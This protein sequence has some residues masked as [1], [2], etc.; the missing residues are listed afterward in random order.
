MFLM[1]VLL[2]IRKGY[3]EKGSILL[4]IFVLISAYAIKIGVEYP[5][6]RFMKIESG[7]ESRSRYA[8]KTMDLFEDFKLAGAGVG[9]FRYAFP[10]Y[11]S[12]KDKKKFYMFAH[13]DWAQYLSEA[14]I[15]GLCLLLAGFGFYIF[16]TLRL[17]ARRK[18][19]YAVSLGVAPVVALTYIGLHS[20]G[21]FSLHTPAN[22]LILLAIMAIGYA[23]LHLERHSRR[24]RMDY[25]YHD[26]P[27][28][29]R[30][31]VALVL[32]FGL[33]GWSGYWTIRHFMAEAHCNTVPNST[34]NRNPLPPVEELV[35]AI[36]WDSSN[37]EYWYKLANKLQR[38]GTDFTDS[39]DENA[40]GVNGLTQ[41]RSRNTGEGAK[42]GE[43]RITNQQITNNGAKLTALERA[44]RL[45]PFNA[46]YHL[47]L[48]WEYAHLWKEPDYHTRWLP[49][50]DI[51]MDRAAYFAGVKNPRLH[52]ELGNY[53]TMRS[54]S[55]YP[56]NPLHHEAW[57]RA[58]WHFQKAQ[59]I[60]RG[61]QSAESKA[62]KRMKKEIRAYVWNFYPDEDYVEQVMEDSRKDAKPLRKN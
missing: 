18:D 40:K 38:L 41:R 57:A 15:V 23:A 49:A 53:W 3:R 45:N 51:S 9:N 39:T 7:I 30:G 29:Y 5:L 1:G 31:T 46:Q 59:N 8:S 55:V 24:D 28:K 14:G 33:I 48:G 62:L 20:Y 27:L 58:C 6:E 4:I 50:A 56:N 21:E 44:V 42:A 37:A 17:W 12:E 26:L 54:K 61:G 32:I 60:E 35:K 11:Q 22:V 52:V 36:E 34:L 25:R 2:V 19:P 43:T 10:K 13:N 16:R 47:R